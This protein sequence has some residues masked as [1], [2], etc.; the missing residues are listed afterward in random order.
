MLYT[1]SLCYQQAVLPINMLPHLHLIE[2]WG[3]LLLFI[4]FIKLESHLPVDAVA[5]EVYFVEI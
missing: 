1:A 3:V 5:F 4:L 2:L